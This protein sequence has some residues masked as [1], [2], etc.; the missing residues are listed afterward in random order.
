MLAYAVVNPTTGETVAE[1]PTMT[2]AEVSQAIAAADDAYRS[3]GRKTTV[4]ERAALVQ[5]V[6]DLHLERRDELAHIIAREMGKPLAEA[7]EEVDFSAD[8]Y[9]YYATNGE[10]FL[11]QEEI[12]TDDGGRAFVRREPIGVLL[13]IMPWNF[14]YYQVARF[15]GPNLVLGN[16]VLLKHAEQCPES[17]LAIASMMKEAG[18]P[19]GAYT[20]LFAT[21]DQVADIIADPRVQAVSVT[22]SERAGAAVAQIAGRNLKK[23]VLEMGGS[24]VLLVLD[25]SDIDS[26]VETAAAGRIGNTGQACNASKRVV[27]LDK[28]F[29]E[30]AEKFSA[31]MSAFAPTDPTAEG[32]ELGPLSSEKATANLKQQVDAA[33]AQGATSLTGDIKVDGNFFSPA[34]LT[35]VTPDMDA[36]KEELF[37]PVAVLYKVSSDEEA[38][39]LANSSPFGLGSVVICEDEERAIKV[40]SE[41]EVGMVFING[42]NLD[43]AQ[44]PFG[45]VKRSGFGREL[46]RFGIEEFQNKKTFRFAPK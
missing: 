4:A 1:Y 14:P 45:G 32:A 21:H 46:G 17:A 28:Y 23:V 25:T 20:N 40:G 11:K 29:D 8:I 15:A 35:D 5:R 30:F 37:G 33:L 19:E 6:A 13:G 2:D 12:P 44:L 16:T 39:R 24:D 3:W 42:V 31:T 27:V 7:L 18:L 22:G 34:V 36:F 9:S 41:L 43:A 26:A 38:V 10:E